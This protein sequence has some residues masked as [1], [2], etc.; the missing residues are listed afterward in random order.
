MTDPKAIKNNPF[1]ELGVVPSLKYDGEYTVENLHVEVRDGTKIAMTICL[2]KQLKPDEKIPTVL[3]QTRYWRAMELRI[4]FRWILD[5]MVPNAPNPEVVTS[6]GFALIYTDVRGTG[7]SMGSRITPFSEDEIKD[8]YDVVEWIIAQPW[9]DGNVVSKGI[10]YTAT[11]T[12]LFAKNNHPAVKAI[13]P[14]HGFWDPYTDV[15]FP[16]GCFDNG[17]NG[18]RRDGWKRGSAR[19]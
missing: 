13:I 8:G 16:G 6:R 17:F 18:P 9:S 14:G 11:T 7:A 15:V 10:S 3:T 12:E 1:K 5:S 4:P 2:P 19:T